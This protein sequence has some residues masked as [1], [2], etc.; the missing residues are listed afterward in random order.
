MVREV[1]LVSLLQASYLQPVAVF[2]EH[3]G[4]N[5][6]A[7]AGYSVAHKIVRSSG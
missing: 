3:V 7:R 6:T 4:T 5:K 1:C 2:V